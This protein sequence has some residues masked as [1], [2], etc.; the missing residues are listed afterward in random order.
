MEPTQNTRFHSE[1]N[2][3]IYSL[4]QITHVAQGVNCIRVGKGGNKHSKRQL[5]TLRSCRLSPERKEGG[6]KAAM[7]L[8][9]RCREHRLKD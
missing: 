5:E 3:R 4:V 2:F 6:R 8:S 9:L 7:I 1:F